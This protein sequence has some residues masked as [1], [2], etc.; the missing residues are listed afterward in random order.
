MGKVK[1][2]RGGGATLSKTVQNTALIFAWLCSGKIQSMFV[3]DYP[4]KS[5]LATSFSFL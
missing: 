5:S 2:E 1:E 4:I 3:A